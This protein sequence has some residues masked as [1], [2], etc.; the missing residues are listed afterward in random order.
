MRTTVAALSWLLVL[1]CVEA[2]A[3][4]R[5]DVGLLLG[6]TVATDEGSVLRF[7]RRTT[8]QATFA[9]RLLRNGSVQL[10]LEIPF[11]ASPRLPWCLLIQ[12]FPWSTP[13]ST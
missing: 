11:V 5:F 6:S 3:Q 13:R 4:T 2:S 10:S 12:S 8:Y 9:W 1:V 7:D